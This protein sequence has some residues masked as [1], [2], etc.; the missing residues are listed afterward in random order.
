[1]VF[2]EAAIRKNILTLCVAVCQSRAHVK[3]VRWL[4]LELPLTLFPQG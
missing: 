1:M 3:S 2:L 4:P